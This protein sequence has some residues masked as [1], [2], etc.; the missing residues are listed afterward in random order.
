M[1]TSSASSRSS[2][3]EETSATGIGQHQQAL[4]LSMDQETS[5]MNC[6]QQKPW[7]NEAL[8]IFLHEWTQVQATN[9]G[10]PPSYGD[11][12]EMAV[13]ILKMNMS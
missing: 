10:D 5:A 9:G 4:K 6:D 1:E 11:A 7:L 13:R 12:R 2:M 8:E 3:D